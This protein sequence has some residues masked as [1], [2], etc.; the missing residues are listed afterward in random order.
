MSIY[1]FTSIQ[2]NNKTVTY[3]IT[4][5]TQNPPQQSTNYSNN[6]IDGQPHAIYTDVNTNKIVSVR[7]AQ[8]G[9]NCTP[10]DGLTKLYILHAIIYAMLCY[11][12]RTSGKCQ[13][14]LFVVVTAI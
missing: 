14:L 8:C 4:S 10:T 6:T 13:E 12:M 7:A 9:S 2:L 3:S 11:A 5:A 1:S